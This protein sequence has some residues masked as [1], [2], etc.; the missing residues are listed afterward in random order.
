MRLP[1]SDQRSTDVAGD[2]TD[3][4]LF[5]TTPFAS[6]IVIHSYR[7]TQPAIREHDIPRS[8]LP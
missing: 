4:Q 3:L 7:P 8:A 1:A 6:G 2:V 5:E